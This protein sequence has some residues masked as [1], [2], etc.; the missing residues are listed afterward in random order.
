MVLLFGGVFFWGVGVG[1]V[2]FFLL[3]ELEGR[4]MDQGGE[5]Q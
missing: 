2:S 5:F 4:F 1:V 3:F